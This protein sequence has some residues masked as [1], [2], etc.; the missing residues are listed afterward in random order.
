MFDCG[1]QGRD[2]ERTIGRG[3]QFVGVFVGGDGFGGGSRGLR[4]CSCSTDT[5][6]KMNYEQATSS[7][8]SDK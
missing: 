7:R 8:H 1:S 6:T 2:R 4:D 5:D 3:V